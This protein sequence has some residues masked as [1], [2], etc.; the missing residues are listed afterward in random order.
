MARSAAQANGERDKRKEP[1]GQASASS[2]SSSRQSPTGAGVGPAAAAAHAA[3]ASVVPQAHAALAVPE[4]QPSAPGVDGDE[5]DS[6]K[7]ITEGL[8]DAT[9]D[10]K[11]KLNRITLRPFG[12]VEEALAL[13]PAQEEGKG[14]VVVWAMN[15]KIEGFGRICSRIARVP[16]KGKYKFV[17]VDLCPAFAER[18]E[19]HISLAP[20]YADVVLNKKSALHSL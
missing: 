14:A 9:E 11:K 5:D 8:D 13:G 16:S 4:A 15:E 2:S 17:S 10:D 12:S 18:R 19:Q 20:H 1:R 3:A 7:I 6:L